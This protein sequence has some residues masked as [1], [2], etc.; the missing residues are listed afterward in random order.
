MIDGGSRSRRA[1]LVSYTPSIY[2]PIV[3][4]KVKLQPV[5]GS[6]IVH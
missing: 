5:E 3:K 4:Q 1:M 6:F 2:Y